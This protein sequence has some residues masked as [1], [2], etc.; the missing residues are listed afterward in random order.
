MP[1]RRHGISLVELLVVCAILAVA[2]VVA[3]PSAQPVAAFRADAAAGEV[4]QALRFARQEAMRS[5]AYRMLG[6]NL[7]RN[8]LSVYRADN[9]NAVADPLDKMDYTVVLSQ[10]PADSGMALTSCSFRFADSTSATA[11]GFD[12]SGNPVRGTGSS[13]AQAQP[14]T[15]GSIQLGAGNATRTIVVDANGRVTTS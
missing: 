9:N 13:S 1:S 12:A 5:G 2:A 15:S 11:L 6:C 7:A 3:L 14:M 4:V 10:V 8:Q